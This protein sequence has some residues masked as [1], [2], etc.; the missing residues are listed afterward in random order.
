VGQLT[1][2]LVSVALG[3]AAC[4][5]DERTAADDRVIAIYSTV[6]R[7][8]AP[9]EGETT[10]PLSGPVFVVAADERSPISLEVQ[11]GVVDELH[12]F[13]TI[14]F[15]DER[16]EAIDTADEDEPV[17]QD[18][19]LITLGKIPRGRTN[20]TIEAQRYER[21]GTA[22]TY[23]IGLQRFGTTWKVVGLPEPSS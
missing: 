15:V 11:A 9:P 22:T 4:G 1:A 6:I 7:A 14:R 16:S 12:E 13:A 21:V 8:L 10:T 3:S 17:H 18:G 5:A 20:V 2:L 23:R 19:V